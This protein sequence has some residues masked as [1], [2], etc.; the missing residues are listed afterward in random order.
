MNHEK[1]RFIEQARKEKEDQELY[2]HCTFKPK[3]VTQDYY[4]MH[5]LNNSSRYQSET[6]LDE[7]NQNSARNPQVPSISIEKL[8]IKDGKPVNLK[9]QKTNEAPQEVESL[10]NSL[11][12]PG[13]VDQ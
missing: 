9:I 10:Q 1:E 5:D 8:V 13:F 2:N 11:Q 7:F 12:P 3:L 6:M 4:Q